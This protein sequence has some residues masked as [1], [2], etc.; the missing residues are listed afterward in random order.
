MIHRVIIEKEV[1]EGFKSRA[2]RAYPLEYAELLV[3]HIERDD[4][5]EEGD[6]TA[7]IHALAPVFV[8]EVDEEGIEYDTEP[9]ITADFGQE[10]APGEYLLGSIHT[11]PEGVPSPSENDIADATKN[12]ER[13]LGVVSVGVKQELGRRIFGVG[14]Y[15]PD[16]DPL[17]LMVS[18]RIP[19]AKSR[20]RL[21]IPTTGFHREPPQPSEHAGLLASRPKERG[22]A[23]LETIASE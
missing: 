20:K 21:K 9:Y 19:R 3:G 8:E 18:E 15:L 4:V 22:I 7:Y 5:I 6:E 2:F 13:L 14:F 17:E 10:V 12:Q 23:S 16:G 11:H 1:L